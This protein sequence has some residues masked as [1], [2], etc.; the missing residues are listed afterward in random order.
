M[1]AD[2]SH[3]KKYEITAETTAEYTFGRIVGDPSIMFRPAHEVNEA[4]LL[5]RTSA[6]IELAK[7]INNVKAGALVPEDMKRQSD[8]E[9]E[10]DRKLIAFHC[11]VSWGTPPLDAKG[12]EVEFSAENVY[13]FFNAIGIAMFD[14]VRNFVGNLYN[15]YPERQWAE[16]DG[17]PLGNSLPKA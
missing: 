3:L 15:F 12:K 13:A 6:N 7:Q 8:Q 10:T 16:V 4:W 5:A 14:P 17:G 9:R 11:A 1:T 2:F